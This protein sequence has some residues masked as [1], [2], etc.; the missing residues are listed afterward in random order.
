[1]H[2]PLT[3]CKNKNVMVLDTVWKFK[4]KQKLNAVS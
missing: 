1:M 4:K 2:V 3:F